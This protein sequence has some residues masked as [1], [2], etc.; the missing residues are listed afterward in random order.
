MAEYY[1]RDAIVKLLSSKKWI[2]P[3]KKVVVAVDKKA[4]VAELIEDH[5][6]G[7]CL[8]GSAWS[9]YHYTENSKSV[10]WSKREG[11]RLFYK[12]KL[13]EENAPSKLEASYHPASI[14]SIHL[15]GDKVRVT[16]S[17]LAG[18]GVAALSRGLAEGVEAVE[19]QEWGGGKKLGRATIILPLKEKL[20]IGVDDTD[21]SDE[22]ATWSLVNEIAFE[23]SKLEGV[24]Y[25]EHAIVQLYPQNP[26]KTQNCVS[27]SVSF[28]VPPSLKEGIVERFKDAIG[29]R[30]F[31]KETAMAYFNGVMIKEELMA[32]SKRAKLEMVTVEDAEEAAEM[33]GVSTIKITGARGL[34][35]AVAAI[36]YVEYPDEAVRISGDQVV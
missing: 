23:I 34:I 10:F 2:S 14:E 17:G 4:G 25:L 32:F 8:G 35:G 22:G 13:S 9:L 24:D 6:R 5:A 3:H 19:V 30:T 21:K 29:E 27:L 1:S 18:A 36:P 12:L 15:D 28:A 33:A 20:I 7:T 26:F 31:S 11:S 16:Y